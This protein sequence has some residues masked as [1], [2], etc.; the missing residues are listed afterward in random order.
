MLRRLTHLLLSSAD[1]LSEDHVSIFDIVL[2]RLIQHIEGPSL[3]RLSSTLASLPLGPKQALGRLAHHKDFAVAAPVLTDALSLS[4]AELVDLASDVSRP[5]LVAIASRTTLS[6]TVTDV[7]LKRGDIDVCRI[8]A[9]NGGASFT[10]EG[11]DFLITA[12]E[13]NNDITESFGTPS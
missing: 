7:L 6:E 5:K 8:L 1:R 10:D 9:R 13:S 2:V 12:A 3:V 4:D 11:Y